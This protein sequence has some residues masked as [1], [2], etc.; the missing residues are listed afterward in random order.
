MSLI[1]CPTVRPLPVCRGIRRVVAIECSPPNRAKRPAE[2]DRL[3][4]FEFY[5]N[6]LRMSL[7]FPIIELDF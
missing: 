5:E 3:I 2:A 7:D 4:D 1:A 6:L